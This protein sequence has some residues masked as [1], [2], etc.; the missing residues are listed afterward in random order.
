MHGALLVGLLLTELCGLEQ[1][2]L[3]DLGDE[4]VSLFVCIAKRTL[5]CLLFLVLGRLIFKSVFV[6]YLILSLSCVQSIGVATVVFELAENRSFCIL[7]THSHIFNINLVDTTLI[8]ESIVLVVTNLA[9]FT[10]LKLLPGL[11]F[12]H[13]SICI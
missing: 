6:E 10:S 1:T 9:L 7:C 12:N 2:L 5:S 11:L 13:G 4:W 8:N 3:V